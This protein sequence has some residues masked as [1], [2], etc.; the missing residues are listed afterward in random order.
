ML[1]IEVIMLKYLQAVKFAK[2]IAKVTACMSFIVAC[3]QPNNTTTESLSINTEEQKNTLTRA[4]Y[5]TVFELDPHRIKESADAA[6]L[7]D[8][9]VGLVAYNS[10]GQVVPAIAQSW[11]T[12]NDKEWLFILDDKAKWSNGEPVIAE[13][14][15]DSWQRLITPENHSP[16]AKY[17][18][19]MRLENAKEIQ[20]Q[21]K[22]VA[23]LGVVALNDHTLQIRLNHP[24]SLLPAMLGHI[25]LLPTFRGV[26]PDRMNFVSNTAYQIEQTRPNQLILK[27]RSEEIPFQTVQYELV[28]RI[29][30]SEH[31]DIVENPLM[32]QKANIVKLPRLCSYYY[33]FNFNDPLLAKK[34]IREAIRSMVA[35]ANIGKVH[36]I[37]SQSVTPPN[38]I[39]E[40]EKSWNPIVV[41]QLLTQAGINQENP[42][43]LSLLYDESN[44]NIEVANQIT[45]TLSQSDL[46]S[47]TPKM[48]GWTEL[49]KLRDKKE[50]QLVRSGWCADYPDPVV[51]LQKFHS[52]SPDNHSGYSN[53]LVDK[54]LE[55]LQFESLSQDVRN[56]LIHEV[57]EQLYN[58]VVVLPLFQYQ[59]RMV[60]AS[61]ILGI[62]LNN[63]SEVIYSKDLQRIPKQKD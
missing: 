16:L 57:N 41:E 43:R 19:Y 44:L 45:R 14:F 36:G 8:L 34:E 53:E 33:E 40:K 23:D 4:I 6:P 51:F 35:S 54:K 15:V 62:D 17:L 38:L 20:N 59:H 32:S 63:H 48:V 52:K 50:F 27:A 61:S 9:L 13:D 60:A 37:P 58:D 3:E 25:A 7:R 10:K 28:N 30:N 55:R 39:K 29:Q 24:N 46:F 2:K 5:S 26:E 56:E 1:C 12:E 22:S 47:I 49:N 21:T 31:F 11:F 42:L 18:V